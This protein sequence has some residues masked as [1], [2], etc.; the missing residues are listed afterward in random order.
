MEQTTRRSENKEKF[1]TILDKDV[2]RMIKER[3]LKEGRT[4]SDV[5]QDAVLKY[6]ETDVAKLEIRIRAVRNFCSRP[7]NLK[8]YELK[9]LMNEDIYEI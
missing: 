2:V 4:I 6:G 3:A 7:F 9:E 5:I 1:G 8:T